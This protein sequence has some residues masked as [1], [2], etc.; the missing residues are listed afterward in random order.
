LAEKN[1]EEAT[2]GAARQKQ[3]RNFK[4]R[5]ATRLERLLASPKMQSSL[6]TVARMQF[7]GPV[8]R[9]WNVGRSLCL[10][11]FPCFKKK[12]KKKKRNRLLDNIPQKFYGLCLLQTAGEDAHWLG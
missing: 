3:N 4:E 11:F 6:L 1:I 7:L 12:K 2:R 5:K 9:N 10:F 8:G